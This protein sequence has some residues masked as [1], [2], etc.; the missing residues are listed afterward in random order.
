MIFVL[1]MYLCLFLLLRLH[2]KLFEAT[3]YWNLSPALRQLSLVQELGMLATMYVCIY[4]CM[5][6]VAYDNQ[7]ESVTLRWLSLVQEQLGLVIITIF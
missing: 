5:Y 3:G 1:L 7:Q 2:K 4:A 6:V